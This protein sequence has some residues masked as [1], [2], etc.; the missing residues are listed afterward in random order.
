MAT[1]SQR[2]FESRDRE[3]LKRE[4]KGCFVP[5]QSR[6]ASRGTRTRRPETTAPGQPVKDQ[7]PKRPNATKAAMA[8]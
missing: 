3:A 8:R 7:G 2:V 5:R 6:C 1:E 4:K